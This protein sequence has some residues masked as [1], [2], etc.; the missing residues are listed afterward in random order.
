MEAQERKIKFITG[1]DHIE[2]SLEDCS[3][4]I[5]TK[6][7]PAGQNNPEINNKP[8]YKFV[9]EIIAGRTNK[10]FSDFIQKELKQVTQ[11]FFCN[12]STD[13]FEEKQFWK[14]KIPQNSKLATI[15]VWTNC[16]Y[17][18]GD[19]NL[20][21]Y[22]Q[23]NKLK[24][25]YFKSITLYFYTQLSAQVKCD[26]LKFKDRIIKYYSYSHVNKSINIIFTNP[27]PNTLSEYIMSVTPPKEKEIINTDNGLRFDVDYVLT[28]NL[29]EFNFKDITDDLFEHCL[30][31]KINLTSEGTIVNPYELTT[32][33][34]DSDIWKMKYIGN[35]LFFDI[36]FNNTVALCRERA[37]EAEHI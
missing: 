26:I 37:E 32:F 36:I 34:Y 3:I 33:T 13:G 8:R 35:D 1:S 29:E 19:K 15:D 28:R 11:P 23:Y 5:T 24:E 17:F 18:V 25:Q 16:L 30:T 7:E 14:N 9:S 21:P 6:F 2:L 4:Y 27:K 20:S 22:E 31:R 10:Q 12:I